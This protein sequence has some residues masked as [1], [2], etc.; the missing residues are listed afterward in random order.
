[1]LPNHF[2]QVSI[3]HLHHNPEQWQ[4]PEEFI[5]ERFDTESP[6]FKTPKGEKRHAMSFTPFISGK[7][8]C[9]G[10]TVG[11]FMVRIIFA[12][13]NWHYDIELEDKSFYDKKPT[14]DI[15]LKNALVK[16]TVRKSKNYT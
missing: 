4:E 11:E 13:I 15:G 2:V 12:M 14:I 5:P 16:A 1:M 3:Y 10:R 8:T 7:R 9:V 6:Y